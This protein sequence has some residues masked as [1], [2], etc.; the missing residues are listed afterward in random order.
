[1]LTVVVTAL[2]VLASLDNTL[3]QDALASLDETTHGAGSTFAA[4]RP[5][6]LRTGSQKLDD[7]VRGLR[8]QT[9]AQVSVFDGF[10]R[11]LAG[12]DID[13]GER[14]PE[15]ATALREDRVVAVLARDDGRRAA[16]VAVPFAA[17][18]RRGVLVLRRSLAGLG[19]VQKVVRRSLLTAGFVALAVA[20]VAG[21]ALA[22][23]LVRQL[24]ALRSTAL[25][26]ADEGPDSAPPAD[27]GHRDE[28][29]DLAR[30]FA[31]MQRRLAAQSSR[32]ARS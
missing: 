5:E 12:T 19:G 10:G 23:R 11:I 24:S 32:D 13:A 21:I 3:E 2:L 7:A 22:A 31:T 20:L 9:D 30:A 18:G 8:P 17:G 28:V 16:H 25:R 26:V 4:L 27:D 29:G 6:Q 15:V 1:V 14:F